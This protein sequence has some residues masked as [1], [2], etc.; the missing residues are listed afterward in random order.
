MRFFQYGQGGV[1]GIG[2]RVTILTIPTIQ[3]MTAHTRASRT[4][5]MTGSRA[6]ASGSLS[7]LWNHK[8]RTRPKSLGSGVQAK[9]RPRSM[10]WNKTRIKTQIKTRRR[11]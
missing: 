7:C 2:L 10:S 8:L 9:G 11:S 1:Q 4:V 5:N 6:Q 3:C